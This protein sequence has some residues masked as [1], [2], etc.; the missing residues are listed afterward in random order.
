MIALAGVVVITIVALWPVP[1]PVKD[2][3]SVIATRQLRFIEQPG[4][5]MAIVDAANGRKLESIKS[6]ADGF[7]PGVM[8]GMEVARRRYG[9]DLSAPY[10]LSQL[11]DGRVVLADP[12]THNE[13][14]LESFG[15]ANAALFTALLH[16]D[17]TRM[18]RETN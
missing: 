13:V 6:T 17:E 4:D 18:A 9:I 2:T 5:H 16:I 10:G 3:A 14:D 15:D 1:P 12:P 11:S 8:Y 7:I